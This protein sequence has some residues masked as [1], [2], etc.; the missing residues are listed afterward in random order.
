MPLLSYDRFVDDPQLNS[1]IV[2]LEQY[3]TTAKGS[4]PAVAYIARPGPA[5]I[6]REASGPASASSAARPG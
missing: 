6:R 2:D 3:Y 1:K 4:L 5:S